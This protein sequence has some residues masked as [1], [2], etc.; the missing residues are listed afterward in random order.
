MNSYSGYKPHLEYFLNN[1]YNSYTLGFFMKVIEL[2]R[3]KGLIVEKYLPD[4]F[5]GNSPERR[6]FLKFT[7]CVYF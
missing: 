7:I 4:F 6:E 5:T 2:M 3:N 1:R